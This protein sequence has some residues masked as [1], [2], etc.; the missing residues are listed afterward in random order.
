M[1]SYKIHGLWAGDLELDLTNHTFCESERVWRRMLLLGDDKT[2]M[3]HNGYHYNECNNAFEKPLP[4]FQCH[5]LDHLH[6]KADF[7]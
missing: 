6:K 5:M 2:M 1:S 3:N 7:E 4:P